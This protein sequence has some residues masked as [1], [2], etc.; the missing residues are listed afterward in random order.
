MA[1][2]AE[3]E[4]IPGWLVE[5]EIESYSNVITDIDTALNGLMETSRNQGDYTQYYLDFADSVS[6]LID[7]YNRDI[8]L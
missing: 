3:V 4:K 2:P 8:A 1:D 6:I 5:P 7:L